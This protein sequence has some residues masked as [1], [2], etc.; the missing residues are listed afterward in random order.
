MV[1]LPIDCSVNGVILRILLQLWRG[2]S[3]GHCRILQSQKS[4]HVFVIRIANDA[5]H[6]RVIK[7]FRCH[8]GGEGWDVWLNYQVDT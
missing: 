3:I 4:C 2:E 8:N 5:A 1:Y 7:Y 6:E